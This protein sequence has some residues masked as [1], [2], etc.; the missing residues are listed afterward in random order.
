LN[1]E[2]A[3]ILAP[4]MDRYGRP[5]KAT[6]TTLIGGNNPGSRLGVLIKFYLPE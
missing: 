5:V 2:L 3:K 6:V 1:R 4:R